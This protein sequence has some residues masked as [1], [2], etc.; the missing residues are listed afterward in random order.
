[1]KCIRFGMTLV[2]LLVVIFIV[3][4]LLALILP[5]VQA[6]RESGRRVECANKL[7]QLAVATHNFH[8]SNRH[9][10]GWANE[11]GGSARRMASWP[12]LLFPYIDE[13]A[14]WDAWTD[15]A[16]SPPDARFFPPVELLVCPS[17]PPENPF[18]ANLSYVANS[19]IPIR[20]FMPTPSGKGIQTGDG[21]FVVR[22]NRT[23]FESPHLT[24]S[25]A[26]R[27]ISDGTTYTLLLSE[28]IQAGEYGSPEYVN[29]PPA[30]SLPND[31]PNGQIS[32][33]C[34]LQLLTG[35]VWDFDPAIATTPP[36]DER[37]I[38]RKKDFGPRAPIET[39]FYF[40]R[41]SSNHPGGVNA[42]MCDA[43]VIWLREDIEYKVY[44]Q[45]MT[46]DAANSNMQVAY[47]DY[48]LTE[49]DYR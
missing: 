12:I 49:A 18:A 30:A 34:D 7:R 28:N 10:P 36:T 40:S 41:P 19:G 47:M 46:S 3:T 32:L 31:A 17:D 22:Y 38:N 14:A 5:A 25:M 37:R 2:E 23:A 26:W 43:S 48:V 15:T 6:A 39:T 33:A 29:P 20:S 1:M 24:W 21:V 45:L 35:F 9:L 44:E 13:T 4:L 27:Q 11:I 42:A 8:D 16:M